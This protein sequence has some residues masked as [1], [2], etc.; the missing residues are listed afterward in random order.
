MEKKVRNHCFSRTVTPFQIIREDRF[1]F[2]QPVFGAVP[3]HETGTKRFS[4][5]AVVVLT[6]T[7][8]QYCVVKGK[9]P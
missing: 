6:T 1:I 7:L 5:V 9:C 8:K 2:R 4:E 3:S